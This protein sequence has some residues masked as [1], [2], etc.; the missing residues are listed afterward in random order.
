MLCVKI[1]HAL[2][3][4]NNY[5][6]SPRLIVR[7]VV[8]SSVSSY[9]MSMNNSVVIIENMI[10]IIKD[11]YPSL[12]GIYLFGSYQTDREWPDSDVDIAI[13]FPHDIAA[14]ETSLV[15]SDCKIKLEEFLKKEVD[16]INIRL[17]S[18]VFQ[19][20]IV[21]TGRL[22]LC[23]DQRAVAEFEMLTLSYYQKLNE[24]RSG[25]LHEFYKTGKA[26]NI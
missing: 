14:K 24:E 6:C 17:V 26:Y 25:I 3:V 7:I 13:L 23:R 1:T 11:F 2:F 20:Q 21:T 9:N 15:F 12:Q 8:L 18:T 4:P 19:F 10:D 5:Q 16:L 22:I